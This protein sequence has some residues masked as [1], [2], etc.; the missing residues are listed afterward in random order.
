MITIIILR[1]LF[2]LFTILSLVSVPWFLEQ[3]VA[4]LGLRT[5]ELPNEESQE[6]RQYYWRNS[7]SLRKSRIFEDVTSNSQH[8]FTLIKNKNSWVILKFKTEH[9]EK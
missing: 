3:M 4:Y 5:H 9:I 1:L 2:D 6:S 8:I 7:I